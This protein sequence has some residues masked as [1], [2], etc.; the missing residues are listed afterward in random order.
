MRV[1]ASFLS[2]FELMMTETVYIRDTGLRTRST[3]L[4][5]GWRNILREFYRVDVSDLAS[6]V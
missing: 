1:S 4:I 3:K 5:T 6:H 2:R